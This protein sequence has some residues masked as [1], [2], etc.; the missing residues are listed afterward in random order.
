MALEP[1][2]KPRDLIVCQI[3]LYK[4]VYKSLRVRMKL[5]SLQIHWMFALRIDFLL[6]LTDQITNSNHSRLNHPG[7]DPA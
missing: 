2:E 7:I 1:Q 5:Y 6:D 4:P 3:T